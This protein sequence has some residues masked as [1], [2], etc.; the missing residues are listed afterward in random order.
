MS[1]K[2]TK[3][4]YT[5]Q[6]TEL[7]AELDAVTTEWE[8]KSDFLYQNSKTLSRDEINTI[9]D[10]LNALQDKEFELKDAIKWLQYDWDHRNWTAAEWNMH[11][12]VFQ[13]ID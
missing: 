13:N 5:K 6:M 1:K 11:E 7:Q 3:R 8:T 4:Q 9:N 2:I 10:E 12:L